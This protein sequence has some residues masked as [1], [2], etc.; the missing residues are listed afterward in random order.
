MLGLDKISLRTLE[1]WAS[2]YYRWGVMGCADDRWLRKCTGHRISQPVREAIYAV[3][4]VCLHGSRISMASREK[5]I[6]GRGSTH[7][8]RPATVPEQVYDPPAQVA[9]CDDVLVVEFCGEDGRSGTLGCRHR[10]APGRPDQHVPGR[11][12]GGYR[13]GIG[14][15]VQHR[16]RSRTRQGPE[17]Q[18]CIDGRRQQRHGARPTGPRPRSGRHFR[19]RADNLTSLTAPSITGP[20][21]AQPGPCRGQACLTV[22]RKT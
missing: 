13:G 19:T 1:R 14:R 8:G 9:H 16:H 12:P 20:R 22:W 6:H 15:H 17:A 21:P 18:R 4:A 3:R 10:A 5:K 7:A 11:R 2:R